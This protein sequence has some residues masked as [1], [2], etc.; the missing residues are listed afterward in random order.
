MQIRSRW[1]RNLTSQAIMV[2][3]RSSKQ[4][5]LPIRQRRR[6]L[7]P[8]AGQKWILETVWQL[9]A[10]NRWPWREMLTRRLA[11]IQ[12]KAKR[13]L[14]LQCYRKAATRRWTELAISNKREAEAQIKALK[15]KILIHAWRG[16][17]TQAS[18]IYSREWEVWNQQTQRGMQILISWASNRSQHT[19]FKVWPRRSRVRSL[20]LK[21]PMRE[22]SRW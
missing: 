10:R 14:E 20:E 21:P 3:Q 18:P 9:E 17:P 7:F 6:F 12:P 1:C 5:C 16:S 22:G 19:D 15:R 2:N 13:W 8:R 11:S 4:L